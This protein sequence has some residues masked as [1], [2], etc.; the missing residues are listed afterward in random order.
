MEIRRGRQLG[1]SSALG[2]AIGLI[3]LLGGCK[4]DSVNAP[5][6]TG[7]SELAL[8]FLLTADPDITLVGS[9][10]AIGINIRD[11]NGSPV[12]GVRVLVE[13]E[14]GPG[15]LDRNFVTTNGNG[16]AGVTYFGDAEGFAQVEAKPVGQD[17]FGT[18]FRSVTIRVATPVS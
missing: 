16:V 6:V 15:H 3:A 1:R 5:Q 18:E 17:Y 11:R 10:S 4:E 12:P 2:L 8:S 7:P 14:F 13:V 9:T